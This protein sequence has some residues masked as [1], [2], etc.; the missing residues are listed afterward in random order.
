MR[1][2]FI[3]F[4]FVFVFGA[5]VEDKIKTNKNTL[6]TNKELENKLSKKLD[7]LAN[8]I[9]KGENDI[10]LTDIQIKNLQEQ[11]GLLEKKAGLAYAELNKL[12]SQNSEL[13]KNKK[14][15]EMRL[16]KIISE[17]FA[18]DLVAPKEYEESEESIIAN[19][20]LTKLNTSIKD[21]FK[22][23][24]KDYTKINDLMELQSSKINTIR[25]DLKD[26][27]AKQKKLRNLKLKQQKS[28]ATLRRDKENYS[29]RLKK[30]REQQEELRKTLEQLQI[31]AKESKTTSKE[32]K[33]SSKKNSK[34]T[35]LDTRQGGV[36]RYTGPKTIAPLDE[37]SV[38]QKFGDYIDPIY[39]IKIYNESVV[40]RSK[41]A[42]AK[43]KSVLPGKVVFA[44]DT[45]IL[46]KVVIVENDDGIHTIYAHL[47][48]IAPTIKVGSRIKKGYVIGRVEQDLTFEVTQ[49]NYHIN[50]L[51]LIVMK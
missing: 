9:I 10:N 44:K 4:C 31:V 30:I 45:A 21:E 33:K 47:S 29:Q 32:E 8:D 46:E 15:M 23:I 26:F 48:K 12:T 25:S 50:P 20:V 2:L 36:K 35:Q 22:K 51:E 16:I 34:I 40:L 7:E 39:K 37:F 11:V 41:T 13:I 1:Y 6:N 43:V 42:D 5:S 19:E 49:Q 24:A 14:Q 28:L 27:E 3:I 17:D 38:K 18:Y